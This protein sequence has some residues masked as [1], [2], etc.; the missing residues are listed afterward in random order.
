MRKEE[1]V[2][3]ANSDERRYKSKQGKGN[4]ADSFIRAGLKF[5]IK[6]TFLNNSEEVLQ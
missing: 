2:R 1:G 5:R 6:K 4:G 3:T